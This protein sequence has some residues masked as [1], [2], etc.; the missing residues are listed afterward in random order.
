MGIFD[1]IYDG[2]A[3]VITLKTKVEAQAQTIDRLQRNVERLTENLTRT[4]ERVIRLEATIDTLMKV[5]ERSA[6]EAKRLSDE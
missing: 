3:A 1:R 2:L 5:S 6:P 4:H